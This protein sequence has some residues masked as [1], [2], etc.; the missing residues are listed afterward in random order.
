MVQ[1]ARENPI[2]LDIPTPITTSRLTWPMTVLNS[3]LFAKTSANQ[4]LKKY[5][6]GFSEVPVFTELTWRSERTGREPPKINCLQ[7]GY[8]ACRSKINS[9]NFEFQLQDHTILWKRGVM[10][11]HADLTTDAVWMALRK[12]SGSL[13]CCS[14]FSFVVICISHEQAH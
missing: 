14:T 9:L 5:R 12:S 6:G 11:L 8:N 2:I 10:S 13:C 4:F 1:L 3:M 7:S